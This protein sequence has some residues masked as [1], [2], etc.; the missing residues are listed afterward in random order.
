MNK[1]KIIL[2]LFDATGNWSEPYRRAGYTVIQQDIQ[3]GA[4]IF[5]DTLP[6]ANIWRAEGIRAHGILAAVPCTDFAAS[7]ARW[8][9]S[10]QGATINYEGPVSFQDRLEYFSAMVLAVLVII[11]WLQPRWWAIEN[12]V[13]RIQKIVPEIGPC[14]LWFQPCDYGDPYTKKTGLWGQFNPNLPRNPVQPTQG[15]KMHR[16]SSAW[17]A[18]RSETPRGFAQAFF[19]ANP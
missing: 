4:D 19:Q 15:S 13:G 7:G 14:R 9:A 11:E 8:W 10:K 18:K 2:S 17:K 3:H 5:A 16:M 1:D 6:D 12:P